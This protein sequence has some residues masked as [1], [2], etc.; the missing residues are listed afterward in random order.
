[1]INDSELLRGNEF[2]NNTSGIRI[3]NRIHNARMC[4]HE[5]I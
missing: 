1:M 2:A 5:S 4:P 3:M